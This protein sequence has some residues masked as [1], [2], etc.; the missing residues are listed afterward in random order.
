MY[1]RIVTAITLGILLTA[2]AINTRSAS[3]GGGVDRPDAFYIDNGFKQGEYILYA[4]FRGSFMLLMNNDTFLFENAG[5]A[6]NLNGYSDFGA[7]E[8]DM[9][10][11]ALNKMVRITNM[12]QGTG[13]SFLQEIS[14]DKGKIKFRIKRNG[15]WPADV[16][17]NYFTFYLPASVF[18]S[19][20]YKADDRLV[21]YTSPPSGNNFHEYNI[22]RLEMNLAKPELNV[23]FETDNVMHLLDAQFLYREGYLVAISLLE[24]DEVTFYLTIPETNRES[25]KPSVRYSQIG[26]S[27]KGEKKAVLEWGDTDDTPDTRVYLIRKHD[28]KVMK[29]TTFTN[30]YTYGQLK[31][32]EFDF[33]NVDQTGDYIIRWSGG[34][35][36]A[37]PIKD[38]VFGDLWQCALDVFIPWQ[39]CHAD[40][41]VGDEAPAHSASHMDDGI[42]V[43]AFF[44]GVDGFVS[45]ESEGTPYAEGE[46]ID[47][48]KGGWFD[49]GDYDQNTGVQSMVTWTL[50]LAYEEFNIKRDT[51][52]LDADNQTFRQGVPDGIP[53]ILQQVEWGAYWLLSMQ[54]ADGRVYPGVVAQPLKYGGDILPEKATDNIKGTGD[55]RHVYVD[56]HSIEQLKFV[57]A[58]ASAARVLSATNVTLAQQ[59]RDAAILAFEYFESHD[60]VYRIMTSFVIP[61]PDTDGR[62]S[63]VIAAATELYMTTLDE[64]YVMV[65]KNMQDSI[66]GIKLYWPC[67][68]WTGRMNYMYAPPFLA[69]LKMVIND[70]A[71][72]SQIDSFCERAVDER[73]STLTQRHLPFNEYFVSVN[74]END[75][76]VFNVFDIYYLSKAYPELVKMEDSLSMIYWLF[77]LHPLNDLVF[78]CGLDYEGPK[79]MFN[80]QLINRYGTEPAAVPG[81]IVPGIGNLGGVLVYI[82]ST[83]YYRYN[84]PCIEVSAGYIF[85]LNALIQAGY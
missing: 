59:C 50:A 39:M 52:T 14:L 4:D 29:Q 74:G 5:I 78:V 71:L 40:V 43:P 15:V 6:C 12:V 41:D 84:E 21:S 34:E 61:Y 76:C 37:F 60:E 51:A 23:I 47:C 16:T 70:S 11:D 77:G 44:P 68:D 20:T 55:E 7:F 65:I 42:R 69:R 30:P 85:A 79:H 25:T 32:A 46:A 10:T 62:N 53:D 27:T 56:Y 64:K 31:I 83:D 18:D 80:G 54:Q 8:N 19:G 38:G 36:E 48:N 22:R 35:T 33:T 3:A 26:Y 13:V 28:G 75:K 82:D 58:M 17:W 66:S 45:Y 72:I 9:T 1:I 81:A 63:T 73:T 24:T 57:V 49:A 67:T 2:C